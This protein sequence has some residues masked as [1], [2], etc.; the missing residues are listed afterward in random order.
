[1]PLDLVALLAARGP[2]LPHARRRTDNR[3]VTATHLLIEVSALTAGVSNEE[4]VQAFLDQPELHAVPVIDEAQRVLGLINRRLFAERYARPC[5]RELYGRRSCT[6]FRHAAPLMCEIDQSLE[7]M[8]SILLGEDQRYLSDGFVITEH[9]RYRG[10]GTGEALVRRVTEHRVE[11]ARYANPLTFLPG[12]IPVTEHIGRLLD[13]NRSF[14]AAYCD[15]N[16]F[17]PL[18][19]QYGYFRG[20]RMIVL[21]AQTVLRNVD[22]TV[23]FVGHIGGD[24]FIVLFQSDDWARRC[25]AIVAMFNEAERRLFDAADVA[26]GGLESEDRQGHRQFFPLSTLSSVATLIAAG[27]IAST[28]EVASRAAAARRQA[29]RGNLGVYIEGPGPTRTDVSRKLPLQPTMPA[30]ALRSDAAWSADS[31]YP[32]QTA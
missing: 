14:P 29:K 30:S 6:T 26:R 13:S 11:A 28:E 8:T 25:D 16:H 32:P 31:R 15:L 21:L 20:D 24:D 2:V 23:D 27:T 18:N 19:D 9:G 10:L 22:S 7:S 17:K 5:A 3:R 4:V 1:M 12:N